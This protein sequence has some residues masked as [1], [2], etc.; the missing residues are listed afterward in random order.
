M[1]TAVRRLR[2]PSGRARPPPLL[3]GS[4][5]LNHAHVHPDVGGARVL[6]RIPPDPASARAG[7]VAGA[8]R[9]GTPSATSPVIRS[10]VYARGTASKIT[11][12]SAVYNPFWVSAGRAAPIT[13]S[14]LVPG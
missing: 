5:P 4:P 13:M 1:P 8:D 2:P 7:A 3:S 14:A 10:C 9:A 6:R 11:V 12:M